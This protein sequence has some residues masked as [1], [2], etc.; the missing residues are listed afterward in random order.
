[1][2]LWL[3]NYPPPP[4][5]EKKIIAH[6]CI[7]TFQEQDFFFFF[8]NKN[9]CHIISTSKASTLCCTVELD[10][11]SFQS[12]IGGRDGEHWLDQGYKRQHCS[13]LAEELTGSRR[14]VDADDFCWQQGP[15]SQL[16]PKSSGD[17]HVY[18]TSFGISCKK[19]IRNNVI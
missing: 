7:D 4:K 16:C 18:M 11:R 6:S 3:V 9:H 10:E 13:A 1:M 19:V 15:S 12:P 2:I 14:R 8:L 17:V 5:K